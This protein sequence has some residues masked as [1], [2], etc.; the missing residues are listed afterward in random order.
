MKRFYP[1]IPLAILLLG[2]VAL[3]AAPPVDAPRRAASA[4]QR[5]WEREHLQLL[6]Q[7]FVQN[8]AARATHIGFK[9]WLPKAQGRAGLELWHWWYLM[10]QVDGLQAHYEHCVARLCPDH[11]TQALAG[12]AQ[13]IRAAFETLGPTPLRNSAQRSARHDIITRLVDLAP[14]LG[15]LVLEWHLFASQQAEFLAAPA[16]QAELQELLARCEQ[17]VADA[18]WAIRH[19]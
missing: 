10:K 2:A 17:A 18:A 1:A 9:A 3:P 19:E 4:E 15:D 13:S 11:P 14:A 8:M 6:D 16:N 5:L 7:A 12:D